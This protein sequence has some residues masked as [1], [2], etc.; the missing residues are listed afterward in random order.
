MALKSRNL[1]LAEYYSNL[2]L[3]Y[4]SYYLRSKIYR[5]DFAEN[6]RNI[7]I[8]KAEKVKGI[9][10][11]NCLPSIFTDKAYLEKY[12][13]LL[14]PSF[15]LP[16]FRY[17]DDVIKGKMEKW[18]SFYYF[19]KGVSVKFLV[20]EKINVGIVVKND[21]ENNILEVRCDGMEENYWV[22]YTKASRLFP[23]DFFKNVIE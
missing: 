5:K 13:N 14:I 19:C 7:C 1:P 15:G 21:K 16:D 10:T 17:K 20:D 2:Q 6:Y 9:A 22:H 8:G 12:I 11:K 18:D 23:E 4:I 3:E